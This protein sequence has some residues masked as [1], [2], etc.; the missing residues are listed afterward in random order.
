MLARGGCRA[1]L[2]APVPSMRRE[3]TDMG[4]AMKQGPGARSAPLHPCETLWAWIAT[5]LRVLLVTVLVDGAISPVQQEYCLQSSQNTGMSFTFFCHF[6]ILGIFC[7]VYIANPDKR[8]QTVST[9]SWG[10]NMEDFRRHTLRDA[11]ADSIRARLFVHEFV[12]GVRLD[13]AALAKHYGVGHLPLGEALRQL[14]HER[15]LIRRRGYR[16]VEHCRAEVD[17]LL[18]ILERIRCF[19]LLRSARM[20]GVS[21]HFAPLSISSSPYWGIHGFMVTPPFFWAARSLHA[22][23]HVSL[24][25]ALPEIEECCADGAYRDELAAS[26]ASGEA[27]RMETFCRETARAFRQ[28]VLAAHDGRRGPD[29]GQEEH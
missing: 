7:D 2:H 1:A 11:L 28:R 6:S 15:L 24:G 21:S 29:P 27:G 18:D 14:N 25:P 26:V 12:P 5:A 4:G 10:W 22:Q 9:F 23:L 8:T 3:T 17:D 13:E 19:E 16:V 20:R